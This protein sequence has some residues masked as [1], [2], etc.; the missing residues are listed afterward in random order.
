M[1]ID[2]TDVSDPQHTVNATALGP[3]AFTATVNGTVGHHLLFL[4]LTPTRP[5]LLTN[6]TATRVQLVKLNVSQST[7]P[8]TAHAATH[9]TNGTWQFV[10]VCT[11]ACCVDIYTPLNLHS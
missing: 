2:A 1:P 7:P 6:A 9:L 11:L 4:Y 5:G 8:A 3:S 10:R